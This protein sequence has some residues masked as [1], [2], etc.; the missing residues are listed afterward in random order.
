M[1]DALLYQ[2]KRLPASISR[3][4]SETNRYLLR[5]HL[6]SETRSVFLVV[7]RHELAPVEL[8]E[9]VCENWSLPIGEE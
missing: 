6:V 5:K 3:D 2:R 8:R 9:F 1:K 4:V 7:L